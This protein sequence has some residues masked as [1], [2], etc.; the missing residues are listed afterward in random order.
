MKSIRNAAARSL[1]ILALVSVC[2]VAATA[3][4]QNRE[5][6][7]ILAKAGG[8]NFVSGKVTFKRAGET[9][10]S[11][12]ST[13]DDL[14]S[15]DAVKTGDNG[16]A[17]VLLNPGSYLRLGEN[18]EFELVDASLD[19]LQLSLTR[20]SVVVEATGYSDLDLSIMFET[21][22]TSV[23]IVRSGI[24]RLDVLPS[25]VTEVAVQKGRAYVGEPG[26]LVKGGKVVRTGAGGGL[27]VA[28]LDKK[29][30]DALDL[31]SKERGKELAKINEKLSRRN[32]YSLLS[33]MSLSMFPSR[34]AST[35]VW[36]YNSLSGCYTFVP[37][38]GYSSYW[39]SPYGHSYGN[40]LYVPYGYYGGGRYNNPTVGGT[41]NGG[42]S[43]TTSN[44]SGGNTSGGYV[45]PSGGS[46]PQ[47]P[48]TGVRNNPPARETPS[49]ERGAG[50]R[51]MPHRTVEPG[52]NR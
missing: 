15:G 26:V 17:E 20:G 48:S 50:E 10:W 12:L 29:D 38:G 1:L 5:S 18:S 34:F 49:F 24:Y 8:V 23:R 6:R 43:G 51:P 30:R 21:P 7:F 9:K 32:A 42:G 45:Q 37:F 27:E 11:P 19:D 46:T 41:T 14:K 44:G 31:W 16:R 2:A 22:R 4:A 3:Q 47:T 25:G 35:G 39:R 13:N 40:Q 52:H 28:K 36:F 33:S